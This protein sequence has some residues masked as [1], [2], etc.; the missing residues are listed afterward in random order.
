MAH[1]VKSSRYWSAA[2]APLACPQSVL[3][4]K[5]KGR[6]HSRLQSHLFF[7]FQ[8]GKKVKRKKKEHLTEVVH[9]RGYLFL[10]TYTGPIAWCAKCFYQSQ[11]QSTKINVS[12]SFLF[13]QFLGFLKSL[14]TYNLLTN[15]FNCLYLFDQNQ[16]RLLFQLYLSSSFD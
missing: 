14:K 3:F 4:F 11:S 7:F 10:Y 13:I 2:W 1:L 5:S 8:F 12:F 6:G 15:V 16:V 9:L